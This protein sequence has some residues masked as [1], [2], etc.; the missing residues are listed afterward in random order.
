MAHGDWFYVIERDNQIGADAV[1]KKIYRIPATDMVP[2][3]LGGELRVVSKEE[4]RDL[5]PDLKQLNGY[6][7][8]KIE[9]LAIDAA[10]EV[11]ISTDND[12]VDDHSGE[13]LFFSIGKI[14]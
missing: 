6:V 3:P 7:Q 8:D 11:F 2:T 14:E 1:T 13:T 9:G 10:G 12:G 5:L 4:V